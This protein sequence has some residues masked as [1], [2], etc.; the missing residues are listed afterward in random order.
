[1]RLLVLSDLHLEV[2][3]ESAPKFN[4]FSSPPDIVVLAGDIHTDARAPG[5]AAAVF[6]EIPVVYVSGNHEFYGGTLDQT[7]LATRDECAKFEN[8]RYLDCGEFFL[9]GVRFLGATLWTD[10]L[11]FGSQNRNSAMVDA[12]NVM[13][14]Y[15]HIRLA[16]AGYRKL[17]PIDTARLHAEHR[18]W[19]ARKL[20]EPFVGP[21]V[22]VTHMAPSLKSIAPEYAS[23]PVS[24][25]FASSLDDLVS[26]AKLWIHGH[27][28][29]SFDY[30]IGQCRVVANP[31]GY[32]K[33]GGNAENASFDANLIIVLDTKV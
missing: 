6:P 8:V 33:K 3:R 24:A 12:N 2:W 26:K 19:L 16:A 11:L 14:D 23:D 20:D 32:M 29:T 27:T 9:E 15:Q 28:H 30:L 13:N 5:W 17:Q 21:T 31:L 22:V 10:F 18:A 25:A 7:N 1:M 4:T